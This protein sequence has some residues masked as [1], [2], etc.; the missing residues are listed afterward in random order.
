[1]LGFRFVAF[2]ALL[3]LTVTSLDAADPSVN[4]FNNS[5]LAGWTTT[6][7]KPAP[8]GWEV[9][10]GVIHLKPGKSQGGNIVTAH[11]YGD[12]SLSFDW[13]IAPK[14]NSGIKY[15]VRDY[16]GKV[17]GL[18][19]Q[20]YDD[21]ATKKPGP[22]KGSTGSLYDLYEPNSA[23]QVNP[24][25]EWNT[26]RIVVRNNRIEHWLNGK[27]V[28]TAY[29]GS[30]EWNK[31]VAESKFGDVPNFAQNSVGKLML[32]DHGSEVW[33]RNARFETFSGGK[34][35][36]RRFLSRLRAWN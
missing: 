10:D 25:G 18:E 33:I 17:L 4:P 35:A 13:K 31:R 8:A 24:P 22:A 2:S 3:C 30:S 14:G 6:A 5:N 23:K 1:M 29:V 20:M 27:L 36:P 19:Y 15:R 16:N 21:N 12:F 28:V 34:S 9:V 7:G 26:G 11:D 32:T